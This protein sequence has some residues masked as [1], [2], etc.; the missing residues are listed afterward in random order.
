MALSPKPSQNWLQCKASCNRH[1][2]RQHLYGPSAVLTLQNEVVTRSFLDYLPSRSD[3][4]TAKD[5]MSL[6]HSLKMKGKVQTGM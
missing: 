6:L 1:Q 4:W 3:S 2:R 5:S